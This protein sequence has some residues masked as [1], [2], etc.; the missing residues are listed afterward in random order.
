MRRIL[1]PICFT[2]LSIQAFAQATNCAQ[3]LRLAQ[4]VYDQGRL[5]E[6][7]DIIIKGLA[8]GDC[9]Q[10]TKVNLYKLLTLAY[11]Y[12]EE[13]QKADDSMLKLLQTDHYFEINEAVDPAEFV[14]LYN[15]FRTHEI[16]RVGAK[17]GVNASQPNVVNSV[18]A[19]E[20]AP[21]SGYKYGIAIHFGGV[22]DVPLND[23]MTLHGELLYLQKKF[24]LD[25]KVNRGFD[26]E[27]K[28]LGQEFQGFETQNY[29]SLPLSFEYKIADKK[30]NP[31]V[32]GGISIDYLLSDKMKAERIRADEASIPE[33][34]F[35]LKPLR[36]NINISALV[37]AGVK[38]KMGGGYFIAE[39]RYIYGL[40]NVNSTETA[41]ANQ[42]ATWDQGYADPVFKVTS[43]AVSGTYVLNVFNPKKNKIKIS[44]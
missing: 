11:I 3:T 28:P 22:V 16:Y 25:L 40:T 32:T 44:Q 23:K 8:V 14:A 37:G 5:H 35:D 27:G 30:Y 6:L 20:L 10:Q 29:F 13:P 4:S 9:D 38:L 18:T 33:T 7:E 39:V 15:T 1:I 19:I 42:Q 12:L 2:F 24:E 21:G 41:F 17:L 34:T 43:L 26:A 31:F 36:E